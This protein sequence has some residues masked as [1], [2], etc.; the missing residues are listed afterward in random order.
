MSYLILKSFAELILDWDMMW[1]LMASDKAVS[2][3][4]Y[5]FMP[6]VVNNSINSVLILVSSACLYYMLKVL[7]FYKMKEWIKPTSLLTTSSDA[8]SGALFEGR[9]YEDH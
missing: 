6:T 7:K 1:F 5:F 8:I 9:R 2:G 4:P 3:Q